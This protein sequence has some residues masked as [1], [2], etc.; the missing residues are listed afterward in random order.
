VSRL[1]LVAGGLV[2]ALLGIVHAALTI[3]DIA[4]PRTFTPPDPHLRAAMQASTVAIHPSSNLWR[5]WIGFNLSHALGVTTFGTA[6]AA[7]ATA[8]IDAYNDSIILRIVTPLIGAVYVVLARLFWFR[9]P[10]IGAAV[11]TALVT[12]GSLLA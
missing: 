1:L 3:R 9:H 12:A 7:V 11:A 4:N 10:L 5:A 6:L 8:N 2:F